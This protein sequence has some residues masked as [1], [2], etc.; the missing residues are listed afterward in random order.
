[1]DG[2]E[3]KVMLGKNLKLLRANRRY[4]QAFLAEKADI[5]ITYLSRI[6]R[7]L[8]F[9]KPE[10][11]TQI[12]AGLDVEVYELFKMDHIPRERQNDH[13]KLINSLSKEMTQKITNVMESVFLKYS[14]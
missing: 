11:I 6:E 12:A 1:M 5:S 4:S 9:P 3:L 2:K 14:K 7:G 10:I 8:K 13:K